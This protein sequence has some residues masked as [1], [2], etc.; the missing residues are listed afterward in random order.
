MDKVTFLNDHRGGN[1]PPPPTSS[2]PR[3]SSAGDQ[4]MFPKKE[5]DQEEEDDAEVMQ[6]VANGPISLRTKKQRIVEVNGVCVDEDGTAERPM[7]WEGELSD[8]DMD[9]RNTPPPPQISTCH[10]ILSTVITTTHVPER[11]LGSPMCMDDERHSNSMAKIKFEHGTNGDP[12]FRGGRC[13]LNMSWLKCPPVGV[14]WKLGDEIPAQGSGALWCRNKKGYQ[15]L[16]KELGLQRT[17]GKGHFA[18]R[19]LCS[20]INV[21]FPSKTAFRCLEKKLEH[22]SNNVACKIMNEAAA[23]VH[24]KNYFDEIVQCGV[25]VDGT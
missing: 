8:D 11:P 4:P 19:K 20:A 7:S 14:V 18:A 12:L 13:T 2:P 21:N 24:K 16:G 9:P 10:N 15:L 1:P 5:H 25:S 22:V 6:V 3:P 23:E 17:I